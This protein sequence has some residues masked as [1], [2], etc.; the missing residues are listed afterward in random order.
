VRSFLLL[1]L[2]ASFVGRSAVHEQTRALLLLP[3]FVCLI[4]DSISVSCVGFLLLR[5]IYLS[6]L[7]TSWLGYFSFTDSLVFSGD[8]GTA[9]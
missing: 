9:A 1:S 8:F 3:C 2:A 6:T 7:V 5:E 4:S